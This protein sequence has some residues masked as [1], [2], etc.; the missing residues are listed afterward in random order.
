MARRVNTAGGLLVLVILAASLWTA[1][2]SFAQSSTH[3]LRCKIVKRT[4]T[5]VVVR[6]L[7]HHHLGLRMRIG[8]TQHV[9]WVNGRK[10]RVAKRG[11]HFLLLRAAKSN[12][13]HKPVTPTLTPTT[14]PTV[15]PTPT[16]TPTVSPTP[17]ATPTVSPTP[18]PMPT[19]ADD[20]PDLILTPAAIAKVRAAIAAK[21]QPYYAT[22]AAFQTRVTAAMS[23]TPAVFV[24]PAAA[25]ANTS[26]IQAMFDKDGK[27]ARDLALGYALTSEQTNAQKVREYLLA[28]AHGNHP[29]T[30]TDMGGDGLGGTYVSH[31][32]FMFAF[33]YDLSKSSQVYTAADR[34]LIESWF[35]AWADDL[36]TFLTATETSS[37]FSDL[38]KRSQYE[39]SG[40]STFT[41]RFVERY[42]GGDRPSLTLVAQL[43]LAIE[44]H[45]TKVLDRLL[46]PASTYTFTVAHVIQHGSAP[47]NDGDG[48]G[49]ARVPQVNI[50]KAGANDNPGRG[51]CV[52]YMT[53]NERAQSILYEMAAN[54]GRATQTERDQVH[55]SWVYLSRYFGSDAVPSPAPNDVISMNV[56]VPRMQQALHLF[57]DPCFA[58]DVNVYT[59]SISGWLWEP[60][61]L[62]PTILTQP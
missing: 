4:S 7:K 56:D 18:T 40:N 31:G 50:L 34:A 2:A 16:A 14:T 22:W 60:H 46:D 47:D 37:L 29:S 52:D 30:V 49:T 27:A 32:L 21:Q 26:T 3:S 61:F 45:Y 43:A 57:G 8:K 39:W 13:P 59:A 53:Y 5:Y 55:Q 20:S 12:K 33:A 62:G 17:T 54:Q 42:W 48:Q 11:R 25:S 19:V 41:Y 10:F 35:G 36:T 44:S 23:S 28:W 58:S 24:G 9:V 15:C 38:T 51:G 1:P 6:H